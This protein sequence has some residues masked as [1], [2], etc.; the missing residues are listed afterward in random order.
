MEEY[1]S[2]IILL[3]SLFVVSGGI[4][5]H[6]N[7]KATPL[8]NSGLLLF[9]AIIANIFGTTGASMLLIRPYLRMNSGH[10]RPY[11]VVFFIFIVSNVGGNAHAHRRSA[12]VSGLSQRRALLVGAGALPRGSGSSSSAPASRVFFILDTIDH[13]QQPSATAPKT[14]ARPF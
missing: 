14:P 1:L 10:I 11:H 2:F 6:V 12:P 7:R 3:A 9:G 13:R 4:V 5:I 8:A